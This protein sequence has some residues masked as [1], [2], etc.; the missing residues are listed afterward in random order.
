[1]DGLHVSVT[2]LCQEDA[3]KTTEIS[4]PCSVNHH[5]LFTRFWYKTVVLPKLR[6]N[7]P[8]VKHRSLIVNFPL[9]LLF[10]LCIFFQLLS[11]WKKNI[12]LYLYF[13]AR[14]ISFERVISIFDQNTKN[15]TNRNG[16]CLSSSG[17]LFRAI[18]WL[19]SIVTNQNRRGKGGEIVFEKGP[20]TQP[21]NKRLKSAWSSI[22]LELI[23]LF[24]Y[25]F[26]PL[27]KFHFSLKNELFWSKFRF[28][29]KKTL[30]LKI[31]LNFQKI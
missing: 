29:R 25:H 27:L 1:M 28:L 7:V 26:H 4:G 10:L 22:C 9:I 5:K 13:S 24:I 18:S 21:T 14:K 2:K 11:I 19:L 30:F 6:K 15:C 31:F 20:W 3:F 17:W 16:I 12:Y 23:F 8:I